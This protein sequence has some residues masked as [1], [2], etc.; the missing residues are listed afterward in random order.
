[1]VF[2]VYSNDKIQTFNDSEKIKETNIVKI[3]IVKYCFI[4]GFG[5]DDK[6]YMAEYPTDKQYL[7]ILLVREYH[8]G[9]Y[10]SQYS[11]VY[12]LENEKDTLD[13]A[14][15]IFTDLYENIDED[16]DDDDIKKQ[17]MLD[18]K[19][20][21]SSV[22]DYNEFDMNIIKVSIPGEGIF[23][24]EKDSIASHFSGETLI[25]YPGEELGENTHLLKCDNISIV[26][27]KIT[28]HNHI[29]RNLSNFNLENYDTTVLLNRI[30]SYYI[31]MAELKIG[32]KIY[33][34]YQRNNSELKIDRELYIFMEYLPSPINLSN[35]KRFST[36]IQSLIHKMHDEGYIHGN[37]NEYSFRLNTN[38]QP[39]IIKFETMYKIKNLERD[40]NYG[41]KKTDHSKKYSPVKDNTSAKDD[42]NSTKDDNSKKLAKM[43]ILQWIKL[44]Y[45]CDNFNDFIE[46]ENKF[47]L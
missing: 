11:Y 15:D 32:P 45:N 28:Y 6:F 21:Y 4:D 2:I 5:R 1:M 25:N 43:L 14:E 31:E 46:Y 33:L 8:P 40:M 19:E 42:N 26:R 34:T 30:E 7:Y 23:Y 36:K 41:V 16:E 3:K 9:E 44:R 38:N 10:S 12:I 13:L 27:K 18:L 29:L 37:L 20:G 22:C 24:Q 47:S 39:R 35:K 17:F